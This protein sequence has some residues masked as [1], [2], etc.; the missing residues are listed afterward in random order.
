[1]GN[2]KLLHAQFR[3]PFC[4]GHARATEL[5]HEGEQKMATNMAVF[6]MYPDATA[7]AEATGALRHAGYRAT[8]IAVL[9]AENPGS[10]D[11]AHEQHSKGW[12][13]AG[14]GAAAGVLVCA[15]I[16]VLVALRILVAPAAAQGYVPPSAVVAGMAAAGCGAVLGWLVGLAVGLSRSEYV[17]KRYVGRIRRGGILLSV[18]CDSPEW[19][20]RAKQTMKASGGRNISEAFEG[21]AD[22][23][24]TDRPSERLQQAVVPERIE[25]Q[26]V[27]VAIASPVVEETGR[28]G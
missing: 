12:G 27:L 22:Y 23:A 1:M 6:G 2:S 16:G 10:K 18:H 5:L 8:D 19:R 26:P 17:A 14:I 7:V 11:L 25:A 15:P 21:K 13:G 9:A 20:E 24:T 3:L 4:N 28:V